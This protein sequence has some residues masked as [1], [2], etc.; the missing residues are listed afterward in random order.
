MASPS[1]RCKQ[2]KFSS[3]ILNDFEEINPKN[4]YVAANK[5]VSKSKPCYKN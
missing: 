3:Y 5:A 1:I 2:E 4:K